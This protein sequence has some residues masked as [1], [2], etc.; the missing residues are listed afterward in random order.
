M[1]TIA[2]LVAS[3]RLGSALAL[4]LLFI[5]LIL[6][7]VAV[8]SQK[9]Y[10]Y[11]YSWSGGNVQTVYF[12]LTKEV[13]CDSD[14]G[15]CSTFDYS[16][17]EE[18]VG[19]DS[20]Q[21]WDQLQSG[22][23]IT[24]LTLIF[25]IGL[26]IL[27]LILLTIDTFLGKKFAAN[28]KS[29][30]SV[31][32]DSKLVLAFRKVQWLIVWSGLSPMLVQIIALLLFAIFFPY[33]EFYYP[34]VTTEAHAVAPAMGALVSGVFMCL[35]SALAGYFINRKLYGHLPTPDFSSL[36]RKEQAGSYQKISTDENTSLLGTATL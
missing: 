2:E 25:N 6:N 21:S 14:T 11:Q 18:D 15:K 12:G 36:L 13:V 19:T 8:G 24:L 28:E 23:V 16:T 17:E 3:S 31:E 22:G 35:L 30:A 20:K 9:W 26:V 10:R 4:L 33:S 1:P 27:C 7:F 34:D 29:A 5:D 32:V